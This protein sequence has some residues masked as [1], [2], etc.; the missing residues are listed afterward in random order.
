MKPESRASR[1][2]NSMMRLKARLLV[3]C[4][5]MSVSCSESL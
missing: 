3:I 2:V 5:A 4:S 1:R